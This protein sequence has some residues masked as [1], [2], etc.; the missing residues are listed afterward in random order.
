MRLNYK[1]FGSGFPLIILH[2]LLGS[3]DNW[4]TIAKHFST[5]YQVFVI[6]LRNHGRSPHSK[7]FNYQ[8]LVSDLLEF[9]QQQ[10]VEKAHFIGHSMGGKTVMRLALEHPEKVAKLIVVDVAPVEYEDRHSTVFKAL[11]AVNL[12]T[13][14]SRQQA[15]ETLRQYLGTD[16]STIQFLM[17]GLY[18]DDD[19][20]FQWRFNVQ[21]LYDAYDEISTGITSDKPF[22]GEALFIKGDK[23]DYI[24][25]ANFSEI[26]DLFPHNQLAEISNAGH[27][28]HA[29][30]PKDFIE[31][32]DKFLAS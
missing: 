5:H 18:R 16:E 14:E 12:A 31:A 6:D 28:V 32:V 22:E 21:S 19:N 30:N 8:L 1:S 11:F 27:W 13:L 15:E 3:L 2:G 7:E 24:N 29:E 26:I 20:K 4:Q 9:M 17:K 23:S 25:A 10:G